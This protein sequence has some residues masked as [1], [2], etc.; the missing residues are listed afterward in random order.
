M[1]PSLFL[2]VWSSILL[3]S[4]QIYANDFQIDMTQLTPVP[5]PLAGN[6]LPYAKPDIPIPEI[7]HTFV[8]ASFNT[9]LVRTTNTGKLRH[10]YSRISTF[11]SDNTMVLLQDVNDGWRRIYSTSSMPYDDN[12]MVTLNQMTETIWDRQEPQ[13]IWGLGAEEEFSIVRFNISTNQREVIKDFRQEPMIQ[14]ILQNNPDIYRM[15]MMDEGK[16][17][18]DMRYWALVLQGTM[19]DYRY[20]YLFTWDRQT[21]EILGTYP[22]SNENSNLDWVGMSPLGNYVLIGGLWDNQGSLQGLTLADKDLNENNFHRIDYSTNHA[23][24][25]LDTEGNEVI[26]MQNNRTDYIDMLPLNRS[27]LPILEAGGSY[28]G[29]NRIPLIR[30]FYDNNSPFNFTYGVHISCNASQYCVVSTHTENNNT[31]D[32]NW[33]SATNVLVELNPSAPKVFYLSKIHNVTA[34]YWEETQSSLSYDG[35][36]LLWVSNW[37]KN[38]GSEEFFLMQLNLPGKK[39]TLSDYQRVMN[40]AEASFPQVFSP[41]GKPEREVPPYQVRYY[42]NNNTYLAYN[43]TDN[44]FYGFSLT[45]WGF[46]IVPFGLLNEYLPS[47]EQAGF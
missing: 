35:S 2:P 3:I 46:D 31:D 43:L 33:L 37:G 10:T 42:P 23:D 30:L 21:D 4:S 13:M 44:R 8:D 41:P 27:T 14:N 16:P 20:R 7:G 39:N 15:T 24:V 38:P 6:N 25:G 22:L 18:Y 28:E 19:D 34:A 36:K 11:N 5:D 17:S 29:T 40:W 9:E 1:K 32:Q 12:F 45:F 26:V 47:A